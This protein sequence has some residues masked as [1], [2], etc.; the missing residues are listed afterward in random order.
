MKVLGQQ[1]QGCSLSILI[2]FCNAFFAWGG[3]VILKN[4]FL[5]L[6]VFCKTFMWYLHAFHTCFGVWLKVTFRL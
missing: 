6:H 4:R 1:G 2:V 5:P 3:G